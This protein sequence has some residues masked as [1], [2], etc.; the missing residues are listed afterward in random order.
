MQVP[1]INAM[2]TGRPAAETKP[3]VE[4]ARVSETPAPTDVKATLKTAGSS[5][6]HFA[7]QADPATKQIV[8]QL[9]DES[10]GK[11]VRQIP[12]EEILRI[13]RA[14]AELAA[15]QEHKTGFSG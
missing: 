13:A 2:M 12:S 15:Q 3:R 14:I 1:P 5:S 4:H 10:T 11:V 6:L 9:V 8:V 7:I